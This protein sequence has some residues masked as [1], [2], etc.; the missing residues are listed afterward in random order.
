MGQW[1]EF[2]DAGDPE[3]R[4]RSESARRGDATEP[5]SGVEAPQADRVQRLGVRGRRPVVRASRT[6][7]ARARDSSESHGPGD[8]TTRTHSERAQG[9]TQSRAG[10][11]REA[12]RVQGEPDSGEKGEGA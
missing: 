3:S 5:I 2:P 7:M 10:G 12:R 11:Q 1:Q 9:P 4:R 8:G 6:Y